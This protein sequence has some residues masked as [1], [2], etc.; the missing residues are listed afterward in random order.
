MGDVDAS[1]DER[2]VRLE[3]VEVEAVAH[4]ERER[5]R[6]RGRGHGRLVLRLDRGCD[7]LGRPPRA[8]GRPAWGR[9]WLGGA[10]AGAGAR[11]GGDGG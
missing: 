9:A 5:R 6:L 2:E 10:N 11:S 4:A 8:Q 1:D 3:A 7:D